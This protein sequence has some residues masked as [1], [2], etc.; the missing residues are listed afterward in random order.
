MH[1]AQ[2][3]GVTD[4]KGTLD[5]HTDADFIV[6]DDDLNVH[7]TYIAGE[8]VWAST[9]INNYIQKVENIL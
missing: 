7:A 2:M 5:I 3:L 9:Q 1:P 6:L 4:R 8:Q